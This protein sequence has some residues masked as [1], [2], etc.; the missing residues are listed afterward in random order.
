V[1]LPNSESLW[2]YKVDVQL[3]SYTGI[4][5][6]QNLLVVYSPHNLGDNTEEKGKK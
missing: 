4:T 3:T 6:E 5:E 2:F 1:V